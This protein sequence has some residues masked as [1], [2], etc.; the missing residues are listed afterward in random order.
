MP[1]SDL[2]FKEELL[3]ILRK[4]EQSQSVCD[5]RPT[6]GDCLCN[7]CL[8]HLTAFHKA[9]VSIS[10]FDGIQVRALDILDQCKLKRFIIIDILDLY[11]NLLQTCKLCCLPTTLSCDDLICFILLFPYKDGLYQSFL[12]YRVRKLF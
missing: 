2:I 6:F 8:S 3:S 12:L 11:R 4:V 10:L 7:I 5:G 1:S 9:P